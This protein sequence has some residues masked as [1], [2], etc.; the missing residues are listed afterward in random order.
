MNMINKISLFAIFFMLLSLCT[1]AQELY[2]PGQQRSDYLKLAEEATKTENYYAAFKYNQEAF[3]FDTSDV[4]VAY[5][6][7][8]S[9]RHFQ[10]YEYA[11]QMYM[12]VSH[13]D[14]GDSYPMAVYHLA[15][16]QQF[17]GKYQNAID[18]YGF[19]ITEF[20]NDGD[21][22]TKRAKKERQACI[23]ANNKVRQSPD[24]IIITHLDSSINSPYSDFAAL[25]KGDRIYFSSMKFP[26]KKQGAF[27]GNLRSKIILY[28]KDKA[29]TLE[30]FLVDEVQGAAHT[31]LSPDGATI[32]YTLCD[33]VTNTKLNCKIY[34]RTKTSSGW[35][36]PKALPEY[37]NVPG[38]T[39]TDPSISY[40]E[41]LQKEVLYFVSDMP[42]GRGKR[43]IWYSILNETGE[44]SMPVNMS[45]VNT[46]ED[47]I[48]PFMHSRSRFLYFSSTGYRG[49][50]G[51]DVYKCYTGGK[52]WGKVEPLPYPV[53]S[54][55][56]DI[57][58]SLSDDRSEAFLSSNRVDALHLETQPKACCY[59][60]YRIQFLPCNIRLISSIMDAST[61]DSL[62][63]AKLMLINMETKDTL[64]VQDNLL[65]RYRIP[66]DCDQSYRLIASK[67]G[68]LPANV[69]LNTP[70]SAE[71]TT[72]FRTLY[73]EPKRISLKVTTFNKKTGAPLSGVD[74]RLNEQ[75]NNALISTRNTGTGNELHFSVIPGKKIS[76]KGSK[77]A[78]TPDMKN[79]DLTGNIDG[80]VEIK[81]Y[82]MPSL[83][84]VL[85]IALYFDND[86]PGRRSWKKTTKET[87]T[88][89]YLKYYPKKEEFIQ[90]Y[91]EGGN[92]GDG[93]RIGAFFEEK[94]KN[95]Y[96]RLQLFLAVLLQE[97]KAGRKYKI[98]IRG[99]TSPRASSAY[100][101]HLAARRIS[102]IKNEFR[103]YKGGVLIPYLK[104]GS[105]L[106]A[107]EKA[108]GEQDLPPEI[109]RIRAVLEDLKDERHSI[110]SP[111]ASGMRRIDIS[112]AIEK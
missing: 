96:E 26:R 70:V 13:N 57:Y 41:K 108:I 54:S 21:Y 24:N 32:Y 59:D 20:G 105:L 84:S 43:D 11:E 65:S 89:T 53:N 77:Y 103:K 56:N 33:Y 35:S 51:F 31:S 81:L 37:I 92:P 90:N 100:N 6:L 39:A 68:Y 87:Y 55:Y 79:L 98:E 4:A 86:R 48:T 112:N 23:W 27:S 8:E 16:M 50:G 10:A 44:F 107:K 82:L 46:A 29:Q 80:P 111:E 45:G 94:L 64:Q 2:R 71:D 60:L 67:P 63:G 5:R 75:G 17:Q 61:K 49:M 58:F 73:L 76:I 83:N 91:S 34:S 38:F 14:E 95:G 106:I 78:F 109:L 85:P 28:E 9:A 18:N 99:Y 101:Y 97:M 30:D 36:T 104:N 69:D 25:Q 1:T 3:L 62:R 52:G 88:D 15:E 7:A 66:V 72:L 42:G 102:S 22:Y 40:D 93:E 110:Y 47:D 12:W 19:Y 74:V